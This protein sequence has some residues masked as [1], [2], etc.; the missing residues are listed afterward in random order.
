MAPIAPVYDPT[1]PMLRDQ[2]IPPIDRISDSIRYDTLSTQYLYVYDDNDTIPVIYEN[3]LMITPAITEDG[4][5]YYY[6]DMFGQ[7]IFVTY[8]GEYPVEVPVPE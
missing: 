3:V 1:K 4:G 8:K 5:S 7:Q 2:P 6:L